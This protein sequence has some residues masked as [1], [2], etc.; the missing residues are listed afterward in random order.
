MCASGV[1]CVPTGCCV[2]ICGAESASGVIRV[3][4][5]YIVRECSVASMQVV[6]VGQEINFKRLGKVV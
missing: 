2:F 4:V 6:L 1:T 3:Y 5:A